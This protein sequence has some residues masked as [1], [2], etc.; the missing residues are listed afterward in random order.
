M[1]MLAIGAFAM[2]VILGII[3]M[4]S[5]NSGNGGVTLFDGWAT[6][7]LCLPI[8]LPCYAIGAVMGLCNKYLTKRK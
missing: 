3:A 6:T 7:I 4:I 2:W 1:L 8:I 5:E